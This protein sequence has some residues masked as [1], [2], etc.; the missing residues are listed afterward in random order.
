[1]RTLS[2]IS[3]IFAAAAAVMA[4]SLIIGGSYYVGFV[5][6]VQRGLNDP[7]S[8]NRQ[9]TAKIAHMEQTLGYQGYLRA[10]RSYRL[11]GDVGAREQMTQRAMEAA[12]TLDGLRALLSG[13][14]NASLAIE[15]IS[16]VVEE[17]A[18][19]ARSAPETPAAALRGSA[20]MDAIEAMPQVPQLEA[21]YLTLRTALERLRAQTS[22]YQMGSIAWALTWSQML[23][24]CAFATLVLGLIAAAGLLQIG[25]TQP[26]KLLTWSLRSIGN[27]RVNQPV[28]GTD[29]TDEIGEM[30]RAGEKLRQSLTETEALREL[31]NEGQ[32][33]IRLEG[34]ASTLLGKTISEVVASVNDATDALRRAA[35]GL[36]E[37]QAAQQQAS[38][39]Q[40]NDITDITSKLDTLVTGIDH[41]HQTLAK[42]AETRLAHLDTLNGQLG[43]KG[44][45]IGEAF[46]SIKSRT[47]HAI[48]GL[49]TSISAFGNAAASVQSIQGA[50]FESCDRISADA[51]TTA[52]SLRSLADQL[53][54]MVAEVGLHL[55]A[56][57]GANPLPAA[58][59]QEIDPIVSLFTDS[60]TVERATDNQAL[61]EG[62][63]GLLAERLAPNHVLM[64]QID[65][66]R[67]DIRELALRMTEERIL[68]TA[69]MPAPALAAEPI[70]LPSTAQRTLADVPAEEILERLRQLSDEMAHGPVE[71][72]E[73]QPGLTDALKAFALRMKPM[74][75]TP[76]AGENL[77]MMA[78]E[79]A[80]HARTIEQSAQEAGHAASLRTELD[81]IT[82][83]L[84]SLAD[85]AQFAGDSTPN[86]LRETAIY[87]GARAESL[88]S[89][90]SQRQA[91]GVEQSLAPTTSATPA[92][93]TPT[94]DLHT[95]TEDLTT[96]A[97][98]IT[99]LERRT[100]E[101]S[102]EAVAANLLLQTEGHLHPETSGDHQPP[103][104]PEQAIAVV[105]EAV[106]RL[107]NIAAA[108]ARAGEANRMRASA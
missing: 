101:L 19:I 94:S 27:G 85:A 67:S 104:D 62:I 69:E 10:Y 23:I 14:P 12:R 87:L 2:R 91:E 98:I 15:D 100:A 56:Q 21:T 108:L 66:M 7:Q 20:S 61:L 24:I 84:R 59:P 64:Q 26:L 76:N 86:E 42:A 16:S 33:N 99:S 37:T 8:L 50:F 55:Q 30:A 53:S 36:Q 83:E 105:Y 35:E 103:A 77:R 17:F 80:E 68:M 4:A 82:A 70:L 57:A 88:F 47:G 51:A 65:A 75:T 31:A 92:A 74:A 79:L 48:D 18:R 13:S 9:A 38:A 93:A 96:L 54:G 28:W 34:E 60:E 3:R 78:P 102:D 5:G 58:R 63:A 52:Q 97:R 106:E 44:R 71:P 1:V 72:A 29:R 90:L 11:T 6:E 39:R 22:A 40:A 107:N 73:E 41:A 95:A 43:E 45:E 25:I 46:A 89:Y 81:A 32:I 49:T